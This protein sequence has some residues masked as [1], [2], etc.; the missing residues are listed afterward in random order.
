[1]NSVIRRTVPSNMRP[2]LDG[3]YALLREQYDPGL[4]KLVAAIEGIPGRPSAS[5][6]S[7]HRT[8]DGVQ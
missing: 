8:P 3:A 1:M 5:T 6:P 2:H 4:E 7:K